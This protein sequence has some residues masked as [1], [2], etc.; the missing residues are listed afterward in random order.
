MTA[1]SC[2]GAAAAPPRRSAR[3]PASGRAARGS[4]RARA[5]SPAGRRR[6]GCRPAPTARRRRW[7]GAHA[8][9]SRGGAASVTRSTRVAVG[10]PAAARRGTRRSPSSVITRGRR[11]PPSAPPPA[12]S[13]SP[14]SP[15]SW[16]IAEPAASTMRRSP[17]APSSFAPVSTTPDGAVAVRVGRRGERHVDRRPAEA[18]RRLRREREVARLDQQVV[19]RRRDVHVPGSS[20]SLSSTS[21]TRSVVHVLQQRAQQVV[22]SWCRCCT[23]TSGIPKSRGKPGDERPERGEPAPRRADDHDG[24]TP[25]PGATASPHLPVDLLASDCSCS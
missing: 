12:S 22:E 7:P 1:K 14:P 23:I 10:A 18:H 20:G 8:R 13:G 2:S 17:R 9:P 6:A 5:G 21:H 15:G 16:T 24:R 19:V 3:G 4:P 11:A 25:R